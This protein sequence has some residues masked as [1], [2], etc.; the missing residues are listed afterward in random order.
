MQ[1]HS[2]AQKVTWST[3]Q[4]ESPIILAIIPLLSL[5]LALIGLIEIHLNKANV[6]IIAFILSGMLLMA[7]IKNG[8]PYFKSCIK[9]IHVMQRW[10]QSIYFRRII[11]AEELRLDVMKKIK[12]L[13]LK[14]GYQIF[15]HIKLTRGVEAYLVGDNRGVRCFL[16][17]C[18]SEA[19]Q[20][21]A[22]IIAGYLRLWQKWEVVAIVDMK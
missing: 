14:D 21:Y 2:K 10:R 6:A 1:A 9:R 5:L 13:N 15:Q 11:Q 12:K 22:E 7:W 16:T 8:G 4:G 20:R 3:Y 17:H 18:V 19:H